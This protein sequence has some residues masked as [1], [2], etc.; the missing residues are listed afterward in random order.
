MIRVYGSESL[1][2]T[3]LRILRYP[4][5]VSTGHLETMPEENLILWF[6]VIINYVQEEREFSFIFSDASLRDM[7]RTANRIANIFMRR[8]MSLDLLVLG[9]ADRIFFQRAQQQLLIQPP[10]QVHI[11]Q[12]QPDIVV[13]QKQAQQI[14]VVQQAQQPDVIVR[15]KQAQQIHIHQQQPNIIVRQQGGVAITGAQG[16]QAIAPKSP[17]AKRLHD[18][19]KDKYEAAKK[20]RQEQEY[21]HKYEAE[22]RKTEEEDFKRRHEEEEKKEREQQE[23]FR[24]RFELEHR[25]KLEEEEYKRK[26]EDELKKKEDDEFKRRH[27]EERRKERELEEAVRRRLLEDQTREREGRISSGAGSR[28]SRNEPRKEVSNTNTRR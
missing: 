25:K 1:E 10:Q 14:H 18:S 12:Q 17:E 21:K 16:I 19:Y 23:V 7:M 11:Q 22:L 20:E 28:K 2:Q 4:H 5:P 3:R 9:Q 27:E 15:Q 8:Y 13:R 26:Y 6:Q 24:R